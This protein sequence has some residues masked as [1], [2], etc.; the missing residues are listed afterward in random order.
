MSVGAGELVDGRYH[1]VARSGEG[2]FGDVWRAADA[3][4]AERAVAMKF[5][6]PEFVS[7][8][9]AGAR[10]ANLA[11]GPSGGAASLRI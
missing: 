1:L 7:H 10:F 9:E 2:T 6:K 5:L 11:D 8:D 4:L 3:R